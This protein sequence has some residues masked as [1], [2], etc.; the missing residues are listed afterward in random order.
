MRELVKRGHRVRVVNRQSR[1]EH[2]LGVEVRRGDVTDRAFTQEACRD[3]G[4]VYDCL[5]AARASWLPRLRAALLAGLAGTE[6]R[7]V[8]LDD[9]E[10][11]GP[12]QGSPGQAYRE[13]DEA[14]PRSRVGKV[15]AR[16]AA[17]LLEAHRAGEVQAAIGRSAHVYGPGVRSGLFG[18]RIFSPTLTRRRVP[19]PGNPDLARSF[20]YLP[21]LA[22]GLA[23]LGEQPEALGEVWH[24]PVAPAITTREFL[25]LALEAAGHRGAMPRIRMTR[26]PRESDHRYRRPDQVSPA[27]FVEAF[28][29]HATPLGDAIRHTVAWYQAQAEGR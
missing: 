25:R 12:S 29:D 3:A 16:L 20:T 19:V 21:D 13:T 22:R 24:L 11:Y 15:R 27:K 14:A 10:V 8:T 4:V 7:L 26:P 6:V 2:P 18:E 28:G 23:V 9:V 1:V 5:N 17:E